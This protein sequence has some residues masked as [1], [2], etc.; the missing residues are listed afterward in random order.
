MG[1]G[2]G[3]GFGLG[4]VLGLGPAPAAMAREVRPD[5]ETAPTLAPAPTSIGEMSARCRGDVGEM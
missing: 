3:L 2:L 1:L 4:L 5:S